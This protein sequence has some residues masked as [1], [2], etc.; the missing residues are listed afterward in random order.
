MQKAFT[1]L[2]FD[3][4]AQKTKE[5]ETIENVVKTEFLVRMGRPL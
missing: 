2:G 1:S 3:Q 4:L 5:G